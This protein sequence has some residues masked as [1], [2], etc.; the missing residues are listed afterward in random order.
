MR[1]W[2]ALAF[3]LIA[4]LTAVAV[5]EMATERAED[6]FRGRAEE[7]AAGNSVAAANEIA[8]GLR[9][10]KLRRAVEDVALARRIALFVFAADGTPLTPARS[11]AVSFGAVSLHEQALEPR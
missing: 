3:G 1:W 2:L 9:Q 5:T 6:A 11:R 8:R 7:L 4:L 10:G